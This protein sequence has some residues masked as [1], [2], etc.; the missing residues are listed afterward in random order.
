MIINITPC[1]K[2]IHRNVCSLKDEMMNVHTTA[3]D[4]L[5]KY[6]DL[7]D[8]LVNCKHFKSENPMTITEF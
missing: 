2:C 3:S 7:Y 1:D 5:D 4:I 6:D 8:F